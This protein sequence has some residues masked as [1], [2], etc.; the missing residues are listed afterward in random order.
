MRLSLHYR[1]ALNSNGSPAHKQALRLHF[2]RQ[3]DT[4]WSQEPLLTHRKWLTKRPNPDDY[5]VLR[6][7]GPFTFAPLVTAQMYGI[8]ELSLV[9]LRPEAPGGL[10]TQGGDLD[11]RLKT[12]FDSLTM[13]RHANA[14]PVDID[15]SN[16]PNPFLCLLE[17]DNL[18]TSLHVRT[19]QLLEPQIPNGVVDLTIHVR[20]RVTATTIGN[21]A[22]A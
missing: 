10:I 16:I 19:E 17:D 22:I 11:N 4:L 7:L 15:P 9:L 8:A 21:W 14:I 13:P 12:L 6:E 3:L 18:V 5:C 1:G 2:H 20:T